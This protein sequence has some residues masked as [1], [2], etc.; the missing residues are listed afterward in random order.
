[1]IQARQRTIPG[2]IGTT[3]RG[4]GPA[5][6]DRRT[7]IRVI[8]LYNEETLREKVAPLGGKNFL[9]KRLFGQKPFD[10]NKIATECFA[11]KR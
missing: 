11:F 4:I 6:E 3:G 2:K 9:L 1:M 8:D 10:E 5:Y 7:G